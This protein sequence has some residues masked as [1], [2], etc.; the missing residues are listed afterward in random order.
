MPNSNFVAGRLA[1][2]KCNMNV[3]FSSV[4]M[5]ETFKPQSGSEP[6]AL[7]RRTHSAALKFVGLKLR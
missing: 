5:V 6:P 1:L 4:D 2:F 7:A 3:R